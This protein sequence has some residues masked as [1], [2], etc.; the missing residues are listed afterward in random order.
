M[1]MPSYVKLERVLLQNHPDLNE[2]WVQAR[3]ADDPAVLGLGDLVLK[4]KERIQPRAGR[5]DLLLQDPDAT[6]RYEV[7]VQLGATDE[8]H[9]VRTLEYWDVERRRYPQYDHCAVLVAEEITGRFLNV[10]SLFNG[11]IPLIAVQMQAFRI[12]ADAVTLVFTTVLDEVFRGP[13]DDDYEQESVDR[14]F[15]ENQA[16]K[17]TLAIVDQVFQIIREFDPTLDLKYNKYTIGLA[18]DGQPDN[19]LIFRPRRTTVMVT[20]RLPQVAETQTR[21]EESGLEIIDYFK[22]EGGYR[23][24]LGGEDIGK[25]AAGLRQ[26]IEA[27]FRNRRRE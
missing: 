1:A 7:E 21:L 23:I 6:R 19:F 24:R 18:R 12:N 17:K 2:R 10:V 25:Q 27:A 13:V 16:S 20:I 14:A 22:R 5:L 8:S 26:F 4:D 3:I 11:S 9:I 15:W